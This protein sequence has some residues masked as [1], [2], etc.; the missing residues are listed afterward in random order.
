MDG[1]QNRKKRVQRKARAAGQASSMMPRLEAMQKRHPVA[2]S[3]RRWRARASRL[4]LNTEAVYR[5]FRLNRRSSSWLTLKRN[6]G[7]GA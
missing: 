1:L 5:L 4:L 3:E 6:T 7:G 2:A